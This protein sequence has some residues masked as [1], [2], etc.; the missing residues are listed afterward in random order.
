MQHA[1]DDL[2]QR[3]LAGAV[4]AQQRVDLARRDGQ[5]YRIVGQHAGEAFADIAQFQTRRR[6]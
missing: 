2:D 3:R 4:L 5:I 1:V 6:G